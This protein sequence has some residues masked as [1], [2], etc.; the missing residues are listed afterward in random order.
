MRACKHDVLSYL[1]EE[2][3][4]EGFQ[5]RAA[6]EVYP[7]REDYS[8]K[9]HSTS[10]T[11]REIYRERGPFSLEKTFPDDRPEIRGNDL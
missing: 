9:D 5:I 8:D 3:G 10:G 7:N 1:Y 11:L 6:G 4:S 2:T